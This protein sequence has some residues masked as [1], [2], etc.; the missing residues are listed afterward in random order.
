VYRVIV[1]CDGIEADKRIVAPTREMSVVVEDVRQIVE[2]FNS[3]ISGP[4]VPDTLIKNYMREVIDSVTVQEDGR[5]IATSTL[6][7]TEAREF[8]LELKQGM[9]YKPRG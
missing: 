4:D 7:D 8:V 1:E 5:I 2:G 9:D 6:Y 3:V